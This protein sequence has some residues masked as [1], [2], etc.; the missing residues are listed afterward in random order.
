MVR[1]LLQVLLAVAMAGLVL[2]GSYYWAVVDDQVNGA[3]KD[4]ATPSSRLDRTDPTEPPLTPTDPGTTPAPPSTNPPPATNP[5]TSTDPPTDPTPPPGPSP[6]FPGLPI[7]LDDVMCLDDVM[8][9]LELSEDQLAFLERNAMVGIANTPY[10]F[11]K[12]ADAYEWIVESTNLPVF[13]TSDSLLDAYHLIFDELLTQI[14][15]HRL[16]GDA[17]N[18]SRTMMDVFDQLVPSLPPEQRHLAMENVAFFGAALRMLLPGEN[19]PDYAEQDIEE[20]VG[21]ANNATGFATPPGFTALEDFT[22]YKPRGHYTRSEELGRYFRAMMWYGRITF[23][24]SSDDET[25]RAV[26]VALEIAANDTASACHLRISSV[27][28]FMVGAADD[29]TYLEYAQAAGRTFGD[30]GP[31]YAPLFDDLRLGQFKEAV[32]KLR[33]PKIL[34]E[35]VTDEQADKAGGWENVSVGMRVFGQRFVPDSYIFQNCVY[36]AV[37]EKPVPRLMPTVLDVMA[38]L[39]SDEAWARED[40]DTYSPVFRQNLER[41]KGE[42]SGKTDEDWNVTLYMSWLD[43]LRTLDGVSP[44]GDRP[45]FMQTSAWGAKQLNAQA[46]SWTQL[47]HDTILYRKQS[48]TVE[49]TCVEPPAKFSEFTYVEPVPELYGHLEGMVRATQRLVEGLSLD[50]GLIDRILG[51]LGATMGSL[52]RVAECELN[53]TVPDAGDLTAARGAYRITTLE[54]EGEELQSKTVLVSDVHTDPNSMS[55]LEES[56]GYVKLMVVVV[57]ANGG[58]VAC[59]GPV[60]EHHEFTQPLSEGRLT[61]EEWTAMLRSGAAAAPAP[62]A[63]DFL[64]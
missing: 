7:D 24:G 44:S 2:G 31:G 37:P 30:M 9:H 26:M 11:D 48:Y 1:P 6:S 14:E 54:V 41:L 39:G 42:F 52:K 27:V 8:E 20:I 5:P 17:I 38:A 22:Q 18:F 35:R 21:L 61:D 56:V 33:K 58:L 28:D 23:H 60:F 50:I 49:I 36:D 64:L 19:V 4:I 62:W 43:S 15:E 59:V 32:A 10:D 46:G 12:F 45:A 34:S 25:R 13:V 47:T 55:C 53:G 40:F 29:L 3:V 51:E 57:P 63:R 16:I